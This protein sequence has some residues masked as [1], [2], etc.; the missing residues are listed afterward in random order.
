[1]NR[2]SHTTWTA[3]LYFWIKEYASGVMAL[4]LFGQL[5][6]LSDKGI[7]EELQ[8]AQRYGKAEKQVRT[9]RKT[10]RSASVRAGRKIYT[11]M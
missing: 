6:T 4:F 10:A 11:D 5:N 1:M 2:I 8:A 9:D 7:A 3:L